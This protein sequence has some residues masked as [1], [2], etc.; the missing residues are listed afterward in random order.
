MNLYFLI[1]DIFKV[2]GSIS[3]RINKPISF[4]EMDQMQQK[5]IR[6]STYVPI[7]IEVSNTW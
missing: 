5:L 2:L 4:Q 1:S 6:V 7:P 3:S